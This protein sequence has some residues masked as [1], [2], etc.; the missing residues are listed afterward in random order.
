MKIADK[1]TRL[2]NYLIDGIFFYVLYMLLYVIIVNLYY[3]INNDYLFIPDIAFYVSYFLYN[4]FFEVFS[5]STLGKMLTRTVVKNM[6]GTKP[7][8]KSVFIR[9][10]LR[11]IPYDQLSFLF[12]FIGLHDDVSKTIVCYK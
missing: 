12:G 9:N 6:D 8:V 10:V 5:N 7:T 1:G 2:A 11:L 4:F 3:Y